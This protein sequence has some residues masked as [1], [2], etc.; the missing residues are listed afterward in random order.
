MLNHQGK[1]VLLVVYS[2]VISKKSIACLVAQDVV[3]NLEHMIRSNY[4]LIV[5]PF[6][7]LLVGHGRKDPAQTW[8]AGLAAMF[9]C[10]VA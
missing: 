4:R 5:S 8:S 2:N 10:E 7:M 1:M 9:R 6:H 3:S